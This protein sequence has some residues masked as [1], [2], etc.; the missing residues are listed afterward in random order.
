[1]KEENGIEK[2]GTMERHL[3]S[4]QEAAQYLA[5]SPMT[6]RRNQWNG[7][8]SHVRIGRRIL[9]DIKDLDKF[10]QTGKSA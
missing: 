4:V 5:I 8:L 6:I 1:M 3:I 9:F 10:I 7:D 2:R